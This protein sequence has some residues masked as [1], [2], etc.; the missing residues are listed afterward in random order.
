MWQSVKPGRTSLPRASMT[1]VG[2]PRIFSIVESSPTAVIF[3]PRI[4]TAWAHACLGFSVYTR[5]WITTIS[6]GFAACSRASVRLAAT[7]KSARTR[8]AGRMEQAF[9]TGKSFRSESRRRV[10]PQDPRLL[11]AGV[12]PAMGRGA[13]KVEAVAWLQ[14]IMLAVIQPNFEISAKHVEEFLAI[15]RVGFA[16]AAAR[17]NTEEMRFHR[18]V[19]PR[20]QLH[21][22][23][24]SGF[25]DLAL[26]RAYEPRSVAGGL[27]KR[28]DVGAIEARNAAERGN[29]RAHLAALERT[30][31]PDGHASGFRYLRQR[32]AATRAKAAKTLPR[33]QSPFRR[34]RD[35]ALT[36]EHVHNRR[37]V[38]ASG[39]AQ[40]NS[41]LQQAHVGLV[42]QAVAAARSLGRYQAKGFPGAQRGGRNAHAARHFAYAQKPVASSLGRFSVYIL[43][44]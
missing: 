2:L 38:E 21:A 44:A 11:A 1:F 43:S 28:E 18:C 14:A 10:D 23:T 6:A 33:Q 15:M 17:F 3:A 27:E 19:A 39:A 24:W 8:S 5:P 7:R 41:A 34:R 9:I 31:E 13:F 22:D 29:G 37:R 32:K 36:L 30:K 26:R 16:A 12:L 40:K 4:A 42:I 35:H 20:K 25:E